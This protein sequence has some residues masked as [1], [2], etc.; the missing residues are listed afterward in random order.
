[1]MAK[2][3]S[4]IANRVK[5]INDELVEN[6]EAIRND[7]A[8][9]KARAAT[10]RKERVSK[11]VALDRANNWFETLIDRATKGASSVASFTSADR[12]RAPD[13]ELDALVALT[14]GP[15][16]RDKLMDLVSSLY[17]DTEGLSEAERGEALSDLDREILDLE[18]TEEAVIRTAEA[19]GIPIMRRRD[20][21]PRA[22][23]A[24]ASALP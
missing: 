9:L 3:T 8:A 1:M 15:V 21:D 6:I 16:I 10:V 14:L 12:F 22:V 4:S 13:V 5:A 7:I 20:A 23:L 17:N 2:K 24:H 19:S 11:A 18:L